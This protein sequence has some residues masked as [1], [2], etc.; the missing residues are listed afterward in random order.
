MSL[1]SAMVLTAVHMCSFDLVACI[2]LDTLFTVTTPERSIVSSLNAKR[3]KCSVKNLSL[4]PI[5][6]VASLARATIVINFNEFAFSSATEVAM[7]SS[8]NP[9]C[10]YTGVKSDPPGCST[11]RVLLADLNSR[12]TSLISISFVARRRS[13]SVK[14]SAS[15]Q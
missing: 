5:R 4:A 2:S 8:L 1:M 3:Q 14:F 11:D 9:D 15:I 10:I 12:A 7:R 13:S 6:S